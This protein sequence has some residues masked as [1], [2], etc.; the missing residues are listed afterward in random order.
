VKA[1]HCPMELDARNDDVLLGLEQSLFG[2]FGPRKEYFIHDLSL[3][4][5]R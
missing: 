5:R 1:A 4:P 2:F 3:V